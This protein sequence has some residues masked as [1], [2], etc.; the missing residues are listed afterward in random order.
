MNELVRAGVIAR[1]ELGHEPE[2]ALGPIQVRP[3]R[4]EIVGAGTHGIIEPRVMQVL[5][6]L[7]RAK[8]DILTRDDLIESC[9]DGVI[10]GEDAIQ[11]CVGQLRKL[12]EAS[13]NAF[14][15]E[16]IPRVG[17]RLK[18]AKAEAVPQVPSTD[19]PE[20]QPFSA[21]AA[22]AVS[23]PLPTTAEPRRPV[24]RKSPERRFGSRSARASHS[25][26]GALAIL[27]IEAA[28]ETCRTHRSLRRRS[29]LRKHE[30]RSEAG[31][32]QRRF[33]RRADQR[34]HERPAPECGVPHFILRFQGQE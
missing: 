33:L 19:A 20:A 15:I 22:A 23:P 32:F 4:R 13:G 5:V 34:S 2:F 7:A 3:S 8:G 9:W 17:Y 24:S 30:R 1:V 12:A 26:I 27:A 28:T 31:V 18:V 16:T 6:A 29:A 21:R 25:R 10:V 11:R 14:A